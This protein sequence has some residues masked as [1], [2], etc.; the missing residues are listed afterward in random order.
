[1]GDVARAIGIGVELKKTMKMEHENESKNGHFAKLKG[2]LDFPK[3][4]IFQFIL[5]TF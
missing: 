4:T 1:M 2:M 5:I 3:M